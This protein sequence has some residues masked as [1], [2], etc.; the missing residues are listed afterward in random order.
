M[1][2]SNG[3]CTRVWSVEFKT[4]GKNRN[5]ISMDTP[6]EVSALIPQG[7][8]PSSVSFLAKRLREAE[9]ELQAYTLGVS[10]CFHLAD[11][12]G[13]QYKSAQCYLDV[14]SAFSAWK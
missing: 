10:E 9:I 14:S 2:D 11:T 5:D 12:R 4:C 1:M 6:S 3:Q 13:H 7:D 8:T